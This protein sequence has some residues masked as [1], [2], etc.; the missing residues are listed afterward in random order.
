MKT[1]PQFRISIF[2][3]CFFAFSFNAMG[4]DTIHVK[5][6]GNGW[7]ML[8]KIV[9]TAGEQFI[10]NWG[11]STSVFTYTDSIGFHYIKQANIDTII[12]TGDWQDIY[13]QDMSMIDYYAIISGATTNCRFLKF[14]CSRTNIYAL[15]VS[16]CPVL[17]ELD[18]SYNQL[19][20][21]NLSNYLNLKVLNCKATQ[22]AHLDIK[23]CTNLTYLDCSS[24]QLTNLDL[25]TN[26][27]I[28]SLDC[29][30]NQLTR[31]DLRLN[32]I[33]RHL[34]LA[35]N[36]LTTLDLHT[37]KAL[38]T[39][40]CSFNQLTDLDLHTNT[41]LQTLICF[42]NQL[43]DLDL[44]TNTALQSL[45]C[46]NNQLTALDLRNNTVLKSVWCHFNQLTLLDLSGS[47]ELQELDCYNNHLTNL[48]INEHALLESIWAQNNRLQLSDL[49]ELSKRLNNSHGSYFGEQ[50][51]EVQEV[52]IGEPV[53]FSKQKEFD[54]IATHFVI[55]KIEPDNL[56][57]NYTIADGII[58]FNNTG[59]YRVIMTNSVI[60][61]YTYRDPAVVIAEINV[62][63]TQNFKIYPN[64]TT[65]LLKIKNEDSK[66]ENFQFFD[67]LG[68]KQQVP[69]NKQ[70]M[71]GIIEINIS[72]LPAGIYFIQINGK[73]GKV[74]KN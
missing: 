70:Q 15:E 7:D 47:T 1:H 56:Q 19:C 6:K 48:K 59:T 67:I 42:N 23:N 41:A 49:Y 14:N 52:A 63:E 16:N 18:C 71:N 65:G 72:H 61:S 17:E 40:I 69:Y 74:V 38:Q 55:I 43:T 20:S 60:M 13:R 57:L 66:T 3:I 12:G 30:Y 73:T 10:V 28:D 24:N 27:I 31:I 32:T 62:V 26:T 25:Q 2:A 44:F 21:L 9:A 46:S 4:N 8:F 34:E 68:K 22:I 54:G 53:N 50:T 33:L 35:A 5:W 37:N 64:P 29:S 51:L 11:D 36:Q 45:A 39:L 58:T